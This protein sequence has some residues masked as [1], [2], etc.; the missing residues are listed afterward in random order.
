MRGLKTSSTLLEQGSDEESPAG[1]FCILSPR[2]VD[3]I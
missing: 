1:A 3:S 2:L